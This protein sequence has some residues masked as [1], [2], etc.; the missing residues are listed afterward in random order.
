MSN[1][2]KISNEEILGTIPVDPETA[3]SSVNPE[4][5]GDAPTRRK[6]FSMFDTSTNVEF[7]DPDFHA[8]F[9]PYWRIDIGNR[10]SGLLDRGFVFVERDELVN[11][12]VEITPANN[13]A[14]TRVRRYAGTGEKG[15]AQYFYLMKQP[16]QFHLEDEANREAYHQK[17]DGAIRSGQ[18]NKR[19]DDGRYD[20]R[21]QPVGSPSS[22]PAISH[23]T[24]LYR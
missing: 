15:E 11:G 2:K 3:E 10:I 23:Q 6:Q 21:N 22:I 13:G 17:I 18:F 9:Y 7:K 20:A 19:A 4:L 5:S 8:K 12:D 14:G 1:Q 16:M 24:K